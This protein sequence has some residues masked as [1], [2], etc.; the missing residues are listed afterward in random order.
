[1]SAGII[2]NIADV[3]FGRP[4][5]P[6]FDARGPSTGPYAGLW[7]RLNQQ[8]IPEGLRE[9]DWAYLSSVLTAG[10]RQG[11]EAGLEQLFR[12]VG[13]DISDPVYMATAAQ[14]TSSESS[15]VASGLAGIRVEDRQRTQDLEMERRSMLL[16]LAGIQA[17]FTG[18]RASMSTAW[19]QIQSQT[20]GQDMGFT[21]DASREARGWVDM[22]SGGGLGGFF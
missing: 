21:I 22:F 14:M 13:G 6:Q 18:I 16:N 8:P 9:E 19:A 12:N 2:G 15:R 5:E 3:G 4:T 1:M 20:R 11:T 17:A 10:A 7:D